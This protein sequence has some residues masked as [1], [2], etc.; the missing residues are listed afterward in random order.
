MCDLF[1]SVFNWT[2]NDF[3]GF[4]FKVFRYERQICHMWPLMHKSQV[5]V[6]HII[7][8]LSRICL[9]YCT[10]YCIFWSFNQSVMKLCFINISPYSHCVSLPLICV[11][12]DLINQLGF[13][14]Y[15]P[16]SGDSTPPQCKARRTEVHTHTHRKSSSAHIPVTCPSPLWHFIRQSFIECPSSPEWIESS[17]FYFFVS[18]QSFPCCRQSR[19][20][21]KPSCQKL[22]K[23]I[24]DSER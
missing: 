23:K 7:L 15:V 12:R 17:F 4:V 19:T 18:P 3:R 13:G 14:G 16:R 24:S 2:C 22:G 10:C 8:R 20:L 9:N 21:D 6:F 11:W 5:S 1:F